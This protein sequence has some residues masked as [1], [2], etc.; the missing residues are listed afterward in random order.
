MNIRYSE[1]S[2]I[3]SRKVNEDMAQLT[4]YP[5][6][7]LALVADG[8]G[9]H[10][11]GDAAS[12]LAVSTVS[13]V[14]RSSAA[15]PERAVEAILTANA[16]ILQ[17][18]GESHRDMKTTLAL[19]WLNE[20]QACAAHVGDTRIYQFRQGRIV[21]Q[22]ADHSVPQMEVCLGRIPPEQIRG[23][24]DRSR[25]TRALGVR[26]DM[27]VDTAMLDVEKGDAFLLCSD[28]FWEPVL[29]REMLACLA[30][31]ADAKAWLRSMLSLV[32]ARMTPAADNNTAIALIVD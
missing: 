13:E 4:S 19:L 2:D 8:L 6:G 7:A 25:L 10:G 30:G 28:G 29:E 20:R 9:G 17:M 27:Q 3:G 26:E 16:R 24:R 1:Y 11:N 21:F 14:I 18:Q 32:S 5:D 12:R 15:S 22:S 23:H 31:A